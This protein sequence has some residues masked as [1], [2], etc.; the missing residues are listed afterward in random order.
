[1]LVSGLPGYYL[2]YF[3]LTL[4]FYII[5]RKKTQAIKSVFIFFV[6]S[7]VMGIIAPLVFLL[8]GNG[9]GFLFI[10]SS[11]IALCVGL[12]VYKQKKNVLLHEQEES[13]ED[14]DE[15][16]QEKSEQANVLSP[17]V[18]HTEEPDTRAEVDRLLIEL[19]NHDAT[20]SEQKKPIVES[21]VSQENKQ[22]LLTTENE[23]LKLDDIFK[24][25]SSYESIDCPTKIDHQMQ[26]GGEILPSP[27]A[28]MEKI[29]TDEK[30]Y[31]PLSKE[32]E[33]LKNEEEEFPQYIFEEKT[34]QELDIPDMRDEHIY[35]PEE[36]ENM[37]YSDLEE[38]LAEEEGHK[39][40]M[41]PASNALEEGEKNEAKRTVVKEETASA[42]SKGDSIPEWSFAS[43][44]E[45]FSESIHSIEKEF[46]DIE[47]ET[48]KHTEEQTPLEWDL[49]GEE[50]QQV[51][52]EAQ[53]GLNKEINF[54]PEDI[55]MVQEYFLKASSALE[56]NNYEEALINLQQAL[57][58]KVPFEARA[59]LV[60]D[61]LFLLKEMGLYK[62]G[63]SELENLRSYII[64]IMPKGE[65][66]AK[67]IEDVSKQIC[68]IQIVTEMLEQ[69]GKPNLPWSLIPHFII[70]QAE[71]RMIE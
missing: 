52:E 40:Y 1:M 62:R 37:Y 70:E 34:E 53:T 41:I 30:L 47:D 67:A 18:P 49:I 3:L 16:V 38:V 44:E 25:E 68:Y 26:D 29:P 45:D 35:T 50:P 60:E 33:E 59:M 7:I 66:R 27:R 22:D 65:R 69:E 57:E 24:E 36:E 5:L 39:D 8:F 13:A 10:V 17:A 2:I 14:E 42:I 63:I 58:Y 32:K 31:L 6:G 46:S 56:K 43:I 64:E 48:N 61:Y 12:F 55:A 28:E 23:L 11:T 54:V 9:I 71:K 51:S 19:L 4:L 21:K 15:M 20:S